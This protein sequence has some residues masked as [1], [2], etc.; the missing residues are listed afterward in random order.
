MIVP[1]L[2]TPRLTLRPFTEDD[3]EPLHRILSDREVIRY[4]PNT[5]PP[6]LDRVQSFVAR[7][8]KHWDEHG[9]GWWAIEPRARQELIGWSGLTFLPETGE[10]EVAYLLNKPVWG[11]GLATEAATT[12]V[13]YG[14]ETV[15]LER[16]IALVHPENAASQRVIRK[17]GMSFVDRSHYFGIAVDRYSLKRSR[18]VPE[19]RA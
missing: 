7:Q 17:L 18:C 13:R 16:I 3:A 9:F 5:E 10:V 8:L 2:A 19:P 15:G 4:L 14:F 6:P 11:Q 1:T 12:C